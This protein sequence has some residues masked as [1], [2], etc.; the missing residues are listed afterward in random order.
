M[1]YPV[2]FANDFSWITFLLAMAK[3]YPEEVCLASIKVGPK[4]LKESLRE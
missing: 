2:Y 1:C 4:D 3:L